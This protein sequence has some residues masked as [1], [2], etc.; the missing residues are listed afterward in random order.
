M[1]KFLFIFLCLFISGAA[2][3]QKVGYVNSAQVMAYLPEVK[4]ANSQIQV[5]QQQ[6]ENRIKSMVEEY[7]R[8]AG[9][10]QR[11]IQAGEIAPKVQEEEIAKLQADETS[12]GA[13][14]NEMRQ[15]IAEKQEA[16]LSPIIQ[17]L[18]DAISAVAKEA[19]LMYIF[20]ASPGNGTLLYAD[21][22]LDMT[23]K[24]MVKLGIN[25]DALED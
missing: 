9:E 16:V 24:V 5:F 14:E 3:A 11:K 22:S 20:D 7:Q 25:P 13:L 1:N 18:Q 2:I 4:E 19:S 8:K 6:Y 21:P 12:I 15:K 23:E 17:K 10:L